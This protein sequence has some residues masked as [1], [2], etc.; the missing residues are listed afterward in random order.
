[1]LMVSGITTEA[2]TESVTVRVSSQVPTV[3]VSPMRRMTEPAVEVSIVIPG[4]TGDKVA[5]YVGVPRVIVKVSL[6]LIL[7]FLANV[8]VGAVE[9][10]FSA[11]LIT[12]YAVEESVIN[13]PAV[14]ESVTVRRYRYPDPF[15]EV[16]EGTQLYAALDAPVPTLR[17]V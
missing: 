9:V 6:R 10:T 12:A 13:N 4:I 2:A 8:L 16:S 5:R 17:V 3:A 14:S 11:G 1:M 7:I 15:V